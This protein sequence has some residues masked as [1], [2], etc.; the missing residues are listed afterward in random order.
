MQLLSVFAAVALLISGLGLA[1]PLA[2]LMTRLLY[3]VRPTDPRI[4]L[5]VG[6]VIGIVA[7]L[8]AVIPARRAARINPVDVL[9]SE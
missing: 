1:L 3:E 7:L 6:I 4:F 2:R 8:A 5:P 9:T